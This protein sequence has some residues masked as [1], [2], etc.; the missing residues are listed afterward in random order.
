MT[1][2]MLDTNIAS[3]AMRGDAGI[4]QRLQ[5]LEPGTWCISAITRSELQYGV[6]LKPGATRLAR[7]VDAFL[8]V[9][10]VSPWST[11]AADAHGQLRAE[12]KLKGT[13]IGVFDEMIAAHALALGAIFVT[14]NMKHF[15]RVPGLTFENWLR[16]T[17]DR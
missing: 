10:D 15:S 12:L 13:S 6:A 9:A 2:Y 1:F 4:D 11:A 7:V 16:P 8:K 14:D 5:E 3:A 17:A